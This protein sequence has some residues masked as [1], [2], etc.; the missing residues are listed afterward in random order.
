MKII[1]I[2]IC[3]DNMDPKGLNRIRVIRYSEYNVG[4][5]D[6][7]KFTKWGDNDP[8]L[9]SPFLPININLVPNINQAVKIINYNTSKETINTEY[10]AGPF[11]K[12]FDLDSQTFTQQLRNTTYGTSNKESVDIFNPNGN[13]VNPKS[14]NSFAKPEDYSI[15]GKYGSDIIFSE[16]GVQIRGGKFLSKDAASKSIRDLMTDYP[17]MSKKA[18]SLYLRK[19]SK[20]MVLEEDKIENIENSVSTLNY[21]VEYELDNYVTP[22]KANMFIYKVLKNYG[23]IANTDYFNS[24]TPLPPEKKLINVEND[25]DSPSLTINVSGLN[26][27]EIAS[28]IRNIIFKLHEKN[29]KEINSLYSDDDLHPFYF[30][31]T[32]KFSNTIFTT[33]AEKK[34]K[35]DVLTNIIVYS[36][37]ESG[38]IWSNLNIKP[39][40]RIVTTSEIKLKKQKNSSEQTFGALTS[41]NIFLLS[42]DTN[43]TEKT[44]D[45]NNIDLYSLTQEDYISKIEPNSYSLVRGDNLIKLL[46]S[47]IKV[48]VTHQHQPTA[49]FT[50][51]GYQDFDDLQKLIYTM[52]ND[53]LNKSI[54]IN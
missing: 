19:F 44:I 48:L 16:N 1:D 23:G 15:S 18:S 21:I 20:K 54:R 10:I 13:Y 47:M 11:T 5:K 29:L 32:L 3:T 49:P 50:Q 43:Q 22:T 41:D 51:N 28:E 31:P 46:K 17:I 24:S 38:L 9:A 8:Y 12:Q 36:N 6:Q 27:R 26:G 4:E 37:L 52:E 45:F 40:F 34:I 14:E 25:N 33:E 2:A 35:Y 30:R 39:P 53:L 42:T 7:I